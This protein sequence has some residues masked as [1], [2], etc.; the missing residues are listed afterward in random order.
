MKKILLPLLL[1]CL[2]LAGC[3]TPKDRFAEPAKSNSNDQA[4]QPGTNDGTDEG[5][6]AGNG[7]DNDDGA[8]TSV[9]P[10]PEGQA[11]IVILGSEIE[12]MYLAR[13]ATDEGLH[14]IVLDPRDQPGGQVIQGEMLFLDE[15]TDD[16]RKTLL[17]GQV[18]ELFT[19]FKRGTIRKKAEFDDY[20]NQLVSGITI[21]SGISLTNVEIE[22]DT[23]RD[24]QRIKSLAYT[25]RGGEEKT[26]I[27]KYWV[28]NT[29]YGAL[30]SQLDVA[31]IPG[32]ETVF[33]QG[34]EK[35]YMASSLM[36]KF[37]NVDWDTFQK[38]VNRPSREER[39]K[40]YGVDTNVTDT[41]TWGFGEVG[42]SYKATREDVFLRGL[43]AL[44][45]RDGDVL[46]NA[47]LLYNVDSAKPEQIEAAVALGRSETDL[48]LK[49]LQ[50][51]LPGWENAEVN[52][53]PEYLYIRDSDRYETE[54]VLQAT[55]VMSGEMFWDNVSIA[56]Y[57]IDLQG[58]QTHPWG[59]S[60]G[61]PDKYGMP[62]RSF[63]TKGYSNVIV[64]GKNVGA[65]AAAYGSARIQ[66]NTS[67]AGEVIGIIL[68]RINGH[69][70]LADLDE[71]DMKELHRYLANEY[72]ITLSGV[73]AN[74]KIKSYTK[75]Q[76]DALNRGELV[77]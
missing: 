27:A 63:M 46:I 18:K 25:T 24:K 48:V 62:L 35:D 30:T 57:A 71:R 55:D 39:F 38:E 66:P 75:E 76:Q 21:E 33:G 64:A 6:N 42:R 44:N 51:Q 23:E 72:S 68:G 54:Y 20:Y 15:P 36:M 70:E 47:L 74:N 49:H 4:A 22:Q 58:T 59:T 65:T 2:V 32:I 34:G 45:Q 53:Y 10:K 28:E 41:F 31:R 16:D 60:L 19:A 12:G 9:D 1:F 43:N 69:A 3:S 26:I 61:K 14:V 40:Q 7:T 77:K 5:T 11:D 67:L 52:G 17:Q 8:S 37:R 13:A 50:E 29:D 73:K 56:G